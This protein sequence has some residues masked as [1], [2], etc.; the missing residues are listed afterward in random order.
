[1]RPT[2]NEWFSIFFVASDISQWNVSRS[3]HKIFNQKEEINQSLV[4]RNTQKQQQ[5]SKK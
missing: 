5:T 1:M 4:Q 2:E 3:S